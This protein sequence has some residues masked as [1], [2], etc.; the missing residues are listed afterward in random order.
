MGKKIGR[1][2]QISQFKTNNYVG[3]GPIVKSKLIM[4][5]ALWTKE[6]KI[7]RKIVFEILSLEILRKHAISREQHLK[8]ARFQSS[9][10]KI[11]KSKQKA[12]SIFCWK[13]F[14]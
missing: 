10:I 7:R 12:D 11:Q 9:L 4:E 14:R 6:K 1:I 8:N 3:V 5:R 13:P 2:Y